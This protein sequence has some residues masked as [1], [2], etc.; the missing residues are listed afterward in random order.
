MTR[1]GMAVVLGALL[2]LALLVAACGNDEE[3]QTGLPNPA[4]VYCEAQGGTLEI[5]TAADGS[6]SGVCHFSDGS[7]CDEWAY[8]RGECSPGQSLEE[9]TLGGQTG[10]ANPASV[11]C[12]EQGGT[13]EIV[14]AGDGSQSGVCHFSDGSQCEEWAYYRGECSPG[15]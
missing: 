9:T 6:Q 7:Q 15:A 8:Y 4:S 11:Y 13:L 12:E 10:L 2:V 14:T 5:V 3:D 1:K